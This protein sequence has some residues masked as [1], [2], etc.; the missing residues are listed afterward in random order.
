LWPKFNYSQKQPAQQFGLYAFEDSKGYL[1]LAIDK[2]KKTLPPLYRFNLLHEGQVMLRKMID[3]FDLHA[4]L[5][6]IDKTAINEEDRKH[7]GSAKKYNTRVEKAIRALDVQLPT[8][9]LVDEGLEEKERLCLLVE[10]GAF[11]GMGYLPEA[12]LIESALELKNYLNPYVDNDY[13]RNNIYAFAA[14]NPGKR[15]NL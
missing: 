14:A 13:I 15:I 7:I 12:T 8:F 3:E 5:C 9:A 1:R 11:W 4:K 10:R 2:K 6:F